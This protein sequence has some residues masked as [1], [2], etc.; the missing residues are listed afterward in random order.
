LRPPGPRPLAFP[1]PPPQGLLCCPEYRQLRATQP[2]CRVRLPYG[3]DAWLVTSHAEAV[4]VL[5]G[6]RFSRAATVGMDLPRET[7]EPLERTGI[8]VLDPPEHSR[9]RRLAAQAFTPRRIAVL[10]PQVERCSDRLLAA[11]KASGQP[12]D[13][14]SCYARPMPL[15]LVSELRCIPPADLHKL[16]AWS[17]AIAAGTSM[18]AAERQR[19]EADIVD[20]ATALIAARRARPGSDLVSALVTVRDGG[21]DGGSELT[22]PELVELTIGVLVAGLDTVSN[23][24]ANFAFML[25]SHAAQWQALRAS[26]RLAPAAVEELLRFIP[27][28]TGTM[29]PRV[30]VEPT[31]LAGQRISQGDVLLVAAESANRDERVFEDGERLVFGRDSSPHLGF[32]Y[33]PHY[34]LG[35]HLARL[36]LQVAVEHWLELLPGLRLAVPPER[37]EWRRDQLVR[38]P[39]ALPVSW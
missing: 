22:E 5:G 8:S 4:T 28:D 18:S 24:L 13:L 1:F 14:V 27:F 26:P 36:Q 3:G 23:Q 19:L 20:Y 29:L 17:D 6:P 30:A 16:Q 12:A 10:R 11:M 38:G 35:A 21:L 39:V 7:P 15:Q 25:L 32:G 34:C 33:G 9:I 37:I 31:T 2:V